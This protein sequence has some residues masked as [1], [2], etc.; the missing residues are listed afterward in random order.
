M[1]DKLTIFFTRSLELAR[2]LAPFSSPV[3]LAV[4]VVLLVDDP[5]ER[6]PLL[7]FVLPLFLRS[8]A[9]VLGLHDHSR[10][11]SKLNWVLNMFKFSAVVIGWTV[12]FAIIS[13]AI[14]VNLL[15]FELTATVMKRAIPLSAWGFVMAA[16]LWWPNYAKTILAD[17][18]WHEVRIW[19]PSSNRRDMMLRSFR[20][21]Q[22]VQPSST[23][24]R[25]FCGVAILSFVI[26]ALSAL[27]AYQGTIVVLT[28]FLAATVLLPILHLVIVRAAHKVCLTWAKEQSVAVTD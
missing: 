27:G 3:I 10:S 4:A 15:S 28:E 19:V 2:D 23:W 1:E 6:Y 16:W 24:W 9:I 8:A 20:I 13:V 25:G 17:W 11:G 22:I 7:V 14:A 26:M 18:P 12:I 5:T 21:R